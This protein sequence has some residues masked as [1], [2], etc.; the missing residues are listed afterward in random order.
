[1]DKFKIDSHKLMYHI[2]RLNKWERGEVIF[3]IYIEV[4]PTGTCNHRCV[5]CALDYLE[6]KPSF[7]KTGPTLKFISDAAKKGLKSIMF[8]GEGEPLLHK[9][10][11]EF[12]LHAKSKNVDTAITTNGVLLDKKRLPALLKNLSWMRISFN[13]ATAESYAKIHQTAAGDFDKVVFNLKEALKIRKQKNYQCTIGAQFLLI[14]KNFRDVEKMARLA[15]SIGLDYLIIKPYSQHP[16]SK[17]RLSKNIDY[18][19]L[20]GLEKKAAKYSSDGFNVVFRKH[21]MMKFNHE[22]PYKKCLGMPFWAYLSSKGDIYGCSAFLGDKRFYYG[23]IYK[24]SFEKIWTGRPRK[25]LM[26]YMAREWKISDCR[27][28]CRI[29]EMNRF[30]WELK[31]PPAHVNFI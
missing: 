21:T 29:D 20:I 28:A 17:N 7:L 27:Q 26:A 11:M 23:N 4:S 18:S 15:K 6:Y 16:F 31:N 2:D 12:I 8:A 9:D 13:A 14:D 22:R 3:P 24:Q 10:I 5:F 1:M 19:K 30:L 25:R